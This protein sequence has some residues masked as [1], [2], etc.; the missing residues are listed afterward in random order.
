MTLAEL[1][2]ILKSTGYPVAYSHFNE[3]V[4][5]P[6]ITYSVVGSSNFFADNK[7]DK[8]IDNIQVELYTRKKDLVAEKLLEDI[9]DENEIAYK[10]TETYIDSEKIFQK[11]YEMR[12]I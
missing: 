11:I 5:S 3:T 10:T 6:F 2:T 8:K 7:V 1:N 12:L 9:L 4:S